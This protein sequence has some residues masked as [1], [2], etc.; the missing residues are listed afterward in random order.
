MTLLMKTIKSIKKIGICLERNQKQ[1][2]RNVGECDYEKDFMKT[3][4]NSD[5]DLPLKNR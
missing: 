4:F 5:N 3:K 1:N 2:Q